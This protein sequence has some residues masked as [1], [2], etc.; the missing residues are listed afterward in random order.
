MTASDG[1]DFDGFGNSVAVRGGTAFVG[2]PYATVSGSHGVGAAYVFVRSCT[3]PCSGS[4]IQTQKL[5][6]YESNDM[7]FGYSVAF[8]GTTAV[9]GA[10]FTTINVANSNQ[11]SA[12]VYEYSG[13]AW[14]KVAR[15]LAND[16]QA[17]DLFGTSV[18]VDVNTVVVGTPG[19]GSAGAAYVFSKSAG[20]W[21]QTAKITPSDGTTN[22]NF[23]H[24]I[25]VSKGIILTG[26]P[27]HP[28]NQ[29]FGAGYFYQEP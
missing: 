22:D 2:S 24:A 20:T 7:Q 1:G 15:L 9:I 21:S 4:W 16:A 8:D 3:E 29:G 13:T 5:S 6:F 17:F 11:G 26:G 18:S 10:D 12:Y 25:S 28:N 27:R 14:V 23:G 19:A